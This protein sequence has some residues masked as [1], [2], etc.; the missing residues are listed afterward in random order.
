MEPDRNRRDAQAGGRLRAVGDGSH[1]DDIAA[2]RERLILIAQAEADR[3]VAAARV[4]AGDIRSEARRVLL[5]ARAAAT[6]LVALAE[7]HAS[8]RARLDRIGPGPDIVIDLERYAE[9]GL[10]APQREPVV[11]GPVTEAPATTYYQRRGAGL[12]R[13]IEAAGGSD[14]DQK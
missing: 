9:E 5:D 10:S 3:I 4:E 1:P 6:R 13:R 14:R 8:W 2:H 11:G 12:R 7:E